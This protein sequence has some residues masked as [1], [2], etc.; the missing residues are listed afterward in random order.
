MNTVEIIIAGKNVTADV[1]P[2]LSWLT[3][4]DNVEA[5][6]DD[7]SLSFE[8]T[9]GKWQSSWYPLQGDTLEVKISDN[10]GAILDCGLFEIDEIELSLSPDVLD[11]KA[12]ATPV[13]KA[14]RT[15]N[16]K[17][18][19]KQTLRK[20]AAFIAN[21]HGLTITGNTGSLQKIE[22]ERT[23]QDNQTDLAF[24][25][26]LAKENG[27]V[28]SVRGKQLV[29]ID[30]DELENKESVATF[31]RSD[32]S[33]AKFTDKTSQ[34]YESATLARRNMRKKQLAKW[35]EV[36][37]GQA[38]VLNELKVN[39]TSA[40]SEGEAKQKTEQEIKD[41]NRQKI[42]GTLTLVGNTAIVA[43]VNINITGAGNFSGKWHVKSSTHTVEPSGY[44]TSLDIYKIVQK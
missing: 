29:F 13:S 5:V 26:K 34:I 40:S 7:V 24:L 8:D 44:V 18:F 41:A 14:L 16:S 17:A 10:A 37:S 19:E 33:T 38:G 23:T 4:T 42:T 21:K 2:Y 3:Y 36:K 43:G 25:A 31:G 11:V 9:L 27:I 32:I 30:I 39:D 6:A 1:S 15:K 28:F 12:L 35:E 20:I 22:F